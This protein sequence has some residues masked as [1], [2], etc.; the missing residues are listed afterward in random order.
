MPASLSCVDHE[1]G[2][3]CHDRSVERATALLIV[4]GLGKRFDLIGGLIVPADRV[5][6]SCEAPTG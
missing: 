5:G 3:G 1:Q 4:A 2:S 6:T